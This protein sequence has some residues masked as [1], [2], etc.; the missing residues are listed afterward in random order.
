MA[1]ERPI[2]VHLL[3]SLAPNGALAGGVAVVIDVLRA[4]TTMIHALAAGCVAVV[5]SLEV[6]EAQARA[7]VLRSAGKVLL[8]GERGGVAL[9]GFDLGNSPSE[10]VA[11]R[12]KK[13]TLVLTTTNGTRA[14]L[15][16]AEAERVL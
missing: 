6:E 3:P 10:Y 7:K 13:T 1:E 15:R 14:L 16:A 12:C 11:A 4:T 2:R 5:P 8:G 9:P